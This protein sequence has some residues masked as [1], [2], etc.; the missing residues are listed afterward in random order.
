ML[1]MRA[2]VLVS[3]LLVLLGAAAPAAFA[4]DGV[5]VWN[6]PKA[7][8]IRMIRLQNNDPSTATAAY[9]LTKLSAVSATMT[10]V[11]YYG[12]A[13]GLCRQERDG[14]ESPAWLAGYALDGAERWQLFSRALFETVGKVLPKG[15]QLTQSDDRFTFEC[16]D[17]GAADDPNA[18]AFDIGVQ[19][20][21]PGSDGYVDAA[22][23][24]NL[25]V[26]VYVQG[27]TGAVLDAALVTDHVSRLTLQQNQLKQLYVD[28]NNQVLFFISDGVGLV[29]PKG[30]RGRVLWN[31]KPIQWKGKPVVEGFDF[32]WSLPV[33]HPDY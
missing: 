18:L 19:S 33:V 12:D 14:N 28:P 7:K 23:A 32:A 30:G 20:G 10:A 26:R 27:N 22:N 31:G 3:A 25:T 1:F 13:V 29:L 24:Q 11:N 4:E 6:D 15:H 17:A 2:S 21:P 5:F 8:A 16:L 9:T